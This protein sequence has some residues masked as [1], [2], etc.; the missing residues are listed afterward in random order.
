MRIDWWTLGL[1]TINLLV[2]VWILGRFLFKPI[3]QIIAERQAAAAKL[4]DDAQASLDSAKVEAAKSVAAR[5]EVAANRDTMLKAAMAEA[6]TQKQAILGAA[7]IAAEKVTTDAVAA[8][9][10]ARSQEARRNGD[11]SS[12]LAVDIAERLFERL[13]SS[14]RIDGFIAGLGE[15]IASLPESAR[16]GIGANGKPIALKV[17]RALTDPESKA[18]NDAI[19]QSVGRPVKLDVVV[20]PLL[21]AGLELETPEAVIRNSLRADL[22][23]ITDELIHADAG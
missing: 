17:P 12:L 2:L 23:K 19:E 8:A 13:P 5:A 11:R 3:S 1:Q 14:A 20:E 6:E 10:Q 22:D 16:A 15:A 18:C 4:L 9:E 7:K 21:I